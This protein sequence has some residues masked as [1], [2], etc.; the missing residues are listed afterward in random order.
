MQ[1]VNCEHVD[2]TKQCRYFWS[3]NEITGRILILLRMLFYTCERDTLISSICVSLFQL[4]LLLLHFL[5]PDRHKRPFIRE[6]NGQLTEQDT[7]QV[8]HLL[9]L[10]LF[11][12]LFQFGIEMSC[13]DQLGLASQLPVKTVNRCRRFSSRC[14]SICPRF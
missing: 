12:Y 3:I 9:P 10:N 2:A 13:L 6:P 11:P 8:C 4:C 14:F 7:Y 1:H 5:L